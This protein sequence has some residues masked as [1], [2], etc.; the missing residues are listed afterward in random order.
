MRGPFKSGDATEQQFMSSR[1]KVIN[2]LVSVIALSASIYAQTPRAGRNT[3]TIRGQEQR[4]YLYQATSPARHRKILFAP[5]DAGCR[6]FAVAIAEQLAKE[7]YDT[8]CLDV[9]HY[10]ES[11]TGKVI[12][13][14]EQ[15]ASDFNQIARWIE[16]K[17]HEPI[18]LVGWSEGAG[19]D[20]AA[21]ANAANQVVFDG[22][23]AIGMPEDN[24]L[25]W[26]WK[27]IGAWITKKSPREPTFKSADFMP[28]I[29]PL[30]LFVIGSTSNQWVTPDATRKLFSLAREPKRLAIVNARDHKYG[31]NIRVFFNVLR[32]GLDWVQRQE[33]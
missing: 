12:L 26:R 6:G 25:A 13:T 17:D 19:L 23:I 18:L 16:Q 24:I 5:G 8:Y 27:D 31:G 1:F 33:H 3:V 10:L 22:I 9:L 11:F 7:G 15:I 2:R 21:A 30:P 28:R 32:D 29:A 14:T 4:I 20:L